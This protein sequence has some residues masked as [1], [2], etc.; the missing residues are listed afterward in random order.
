MIA[1]QDAAVVRIEALH[2]VLGEDDRP[3]GSGDDIEYPGADIPRPCGA[4]ADGRGK[5]RLRT[6]GCGGGRQPGSGHVSTGG[7]R[8]VL[9]RIRAG[10]RS[11]IIA[12]RRWLRGTGVVPR[13]ARVT[14]ATNRRSGLLQ[15]RRTGWGCER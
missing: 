2:A 13:A 1:P 8:A 15:A 10:S 11:A 7:A 4:G 5:S 6:A 9:G 12:G 3:A 14:R